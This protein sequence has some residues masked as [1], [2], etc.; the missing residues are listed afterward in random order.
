MGTIITAMVLAGLIGLILYSMVK[1]KKN[2]KSLHCGC[3]CKNCG[4]CGCKKNG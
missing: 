3:D 2:G 4:G 1:D